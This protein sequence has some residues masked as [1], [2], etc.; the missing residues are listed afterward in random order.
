MPDKGLTGRWDKYEAEPMADRFD[1]QACGD[2]G[3]EPPG[4]PAWVPPHPFGRRLLAASRGS[5]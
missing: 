2:R 4:R 5:T 1:E 3:T